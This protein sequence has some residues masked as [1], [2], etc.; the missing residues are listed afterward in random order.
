MPTEQYASAP[1]PIILFIIL[2]AIWYFL[3][4]KPQMNKQKEHKQR[5]SSLKKNDEVITAGG[6]HGTI[7]NVKDKTVI[8]R[9]DDTVKIEVDKEAISTVTNAGA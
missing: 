7:V 8:V 1:S 9:V 2:G 3:I 4:I 6:I 5:V